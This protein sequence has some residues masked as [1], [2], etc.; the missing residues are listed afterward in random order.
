M[1]WVTRRKFLR[2]SAEFACSGILGSTG[3]AG[4]EI[5]RSVK[6]GEASDRLHVAVIGVNGRG[7]DHV[8]S[9]SA[10]HNCLV[11]TIC[12][13]D[14][15][16]IG[17]SMRHIESVQGKAPRYEQ[18]LRR[19]LDDRSIDIVTVATPNHWH[20]LI[21]IWAMQAG[22]DVY[23]EKPVSHN[24]S[25]GRR[26]IEAARRYHRICQTGMQSRSMPGM[27]E[28]MEYLHSGK[29]G[30]VN[31]ARGIC[32]K[33]RCGIGKV[34]RA[35]PISRTVNYDLW[36]GPAPLAPLLRRNLHYDWHW[37]WNYGNGDLGNQGIH[38]LDKAR[39]GLGKSELP[40]SVLSL[41]GR[42]GYVDDGQTPNTLLSVFDFGNC[43]LIFEVRGLP[44]RNPYPG[45]DFDKVPTT[46]QNFVGNIFYGSEGTLICPSYSEGIALDHS[47]EVI[48]R[49][50]GA[51]DHTRN[52]LNAVRNHD[53]SLLHADIEEGHLSSAL[54]HLGNV[55]FIL[56]TFHPFSTQEKAFRENKEALETLTRMEDH[57]KENKVRLDKS[58]CRIGRKLDFDPKRESFVNDP[59]ANMLLTRD[60]RKPFVVPARI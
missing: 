21:A 11:S 42:F 58:A 54:C 59:A 50:A 34:S 31:L 4:S 27:R 48:R 14:E 45:K 9:F 29:L 3:D 32:Y 33:L 12:D 39:W 6:R 17:R 1:T 15:G 35:Q 30:K 53:R 7:Y 22:K 37:V 55:S 51:G 46:P 2:R 56:G 16:V 41:G 8:R 19:V 10:Q 38:E 47:G 60:Y 43:E 49:F 28:A 40:H 13:A 20:A 23:L 25:E 24:I 52:F 18:D 44:S 26:V 36:C 57:L 5:D